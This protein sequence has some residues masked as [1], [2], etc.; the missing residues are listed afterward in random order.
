MPARASWLNRLPELPAETSA[1]V[2]TPI[3]NA[4]ASGRIIVVSAVHVGGTD[5]P[6]IVFASARAA[7]TADPPARF[8]ITGKRVG[9]TGAYP[10]Q[11]CV[12][13]QPLT[14]PSVWKPV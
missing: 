14:M 13:A 5:S 1:A 2:P 9:G 7:D 6:P 11:V 12:P 3:G 10:G 8:V 4:T